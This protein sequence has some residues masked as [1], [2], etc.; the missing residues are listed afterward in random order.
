MPV[1]QDL[2]DAIDAALGGAVP[3]SYNN[4]SAA[5]D[6]F[7]GFIWSIVVAAAKAEG[8]TVTYEDVS[9][10]VAG[11]LVFRTTPGN[12]YSKADDY[13][14][15][16]IRFGDASELE[17]HIGVYVSGRSGVIH[18]CDVAI[19]D[20]NEGIICR[21]EE[22]HPRSS[23]LVA[24]LECKFH[25]G[26]LKLGVAR[27]FLGLAEEL[28]KNDRFLV[29]NASSQIVEKMMAYH[30]AEWEF[31]LDLTDLTVVSNLQSRLARTFRNFK[32]K[33]FRP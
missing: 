3:S 28:T 7:E 25:A 29:T 17:A 26:T 22:V 6:V 21:S 2:L 18:E 30:K 14:H 32:A 10:N 1:Q 27:G 19:I 12:I 16:V 9:G 31:R 8:A 5:N 4:A 20:R 24:A 11:Q 33:N 23:K 13:T 15:A